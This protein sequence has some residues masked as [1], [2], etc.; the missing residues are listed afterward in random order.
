[1]TKAEAIETL[2][3]EVLVDVDPVIPAIFDVSR[4]HAYQ[5]VRDGLLPTMKVGAKRVKIVTAPLRR[6]L[7]IE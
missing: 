3:N 7:G 4:P 6:Q 5:M 1:M 2:K